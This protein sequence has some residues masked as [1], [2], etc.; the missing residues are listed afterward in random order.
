MLYA[1]F[2]NA[3]FYYA[4]CTSTIDR[5]QPYLA[6]GRLAEG[7]VWIA[8]YQTNGRGQRQN[9]WES[10]VGKNLLFTLLL[11]PTVLAAAAVFAL[12]MIT[13]LAVYEAAA[14]WLNPINVAIK[15]PNDIYYK[16]K[17]LGGILIA[18][19]IGKTHVKSAVISVGFNVNQLTFK[20][21]F[22]T[23]LALHHAAPLDRSLL[24]NQMLHALGMYYGQLQANKIESLWTCY[25]DK[26]YC[27][28]EWH[29]FQTVNGYKHGKIVTVNSIG[30]LVIET[31]HGQQELYNPKEIA[32]VS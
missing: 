12:N 9:N 15:W 14:Y 28:N 25:L 1:P 24:L 27:K 19:Q 17:K 20:T 4:E 31:Y 21:P 6:Q 32:M 10:E 26:L 18:T 29:G 11:Y 7:T 5:I 3:S 8:D 2:P 13:S 22:A 16:N 23:S 30:Q